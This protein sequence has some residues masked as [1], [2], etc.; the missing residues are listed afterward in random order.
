MTIKTFL[1]FNSVQQFDNV[2]FLL[3]SYKGDI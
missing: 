2:V 3:Q 1:T